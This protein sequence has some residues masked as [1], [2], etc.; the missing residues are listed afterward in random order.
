LD[1]D[2]DPEPVSVSKHASPVQ[3]GKR[4]PAHR[5][6]GVVSVQAHVPCAQLVLN[7][8]ARDLSQPGELL[9][10]ERAAETRGV[11]VNPG[12]IDIF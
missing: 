11:R 2:F 10:F 4:Q 3:L 8:F 12:V 9:D 6:I 7:A 1:L 5:I